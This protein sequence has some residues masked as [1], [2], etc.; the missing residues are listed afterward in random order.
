[1]AIA[2]IWIFAGVAIFYSQISSSASTNQAESFVNTYQNLTVEPIYL[3]VAAATSL[4]IT[5][6]L[7]FKSNAEI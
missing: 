1:M 4:V 3:F 7:C 2:V 6:Y 5:L